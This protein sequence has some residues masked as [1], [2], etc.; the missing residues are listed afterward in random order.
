MGP[1]LAKTL[2]LLAGF[3]GFYE[4]DRAVAKRNN[5]IS[6]IHSIIQRM[7]RKRAEITPEEYFALIEE[8]RQRTKEHYNSAQEP[9]Y[10]TNYPE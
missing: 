4:L 10:R 7:D 8:A 6:M 9:I 1:G 3:Y 5:G 2:A